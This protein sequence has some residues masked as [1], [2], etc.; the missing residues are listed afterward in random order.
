LNTL[1][2]KTESNFTPDDKVKKALITSLKI[3]ENPGV[4]REALNVLKK[5]PKDEEIKEAFLYVL[6]NDRNSGLRVSAINALVDWKQE[7]ISLDDEMRNILNKKAEADPNEYVR[8]RAASLLKED[9]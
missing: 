3:D 4:R 8:I 7:D 2:V 5:F 9:I 1:A 6:S